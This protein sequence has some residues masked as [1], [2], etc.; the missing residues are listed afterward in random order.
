MK[1]KRREKAVK[2]T[3]KAKHHNVREMNRDDSIT[4]GKNADRKIIKDEIGAND[5]EIKVKCVKKRKASKT[6]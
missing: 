6:G 4:D 3:K 5:Q 2:N 1:G